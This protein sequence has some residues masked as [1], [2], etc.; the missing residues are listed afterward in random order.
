MD[1]LQATAE[2]H[3][4]AP[5]IDDGQRMESYAELLDEVKD[6]ARRLHEQGL[7][8]GDRIGVLAHR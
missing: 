5:A 7:A 4:D 8:A 1:I 6:K 2:A 3:P